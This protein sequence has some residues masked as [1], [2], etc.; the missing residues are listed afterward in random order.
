MLGIDKQQKSGHIANYTSVNT[1][2]QQEMN[3]FLHF[4]SPLVTKEIDSRA[5]SLSYQFA[6]NHSNGEPESSVSETPP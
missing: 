6:P 4:E 2:R 3:E 1:A 5:H